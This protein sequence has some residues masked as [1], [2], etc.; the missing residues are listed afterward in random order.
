MASFPGFWFCTEMLSLNSSKDTLYILASW[1]TTSLTCVLFHVPRCT[2]MWTLQMGKVFQT[3]WLCPIQQSHMHTCPDRRPL[4]WQDLQD[5]IRSAV[6]ITLT[7]RLMCAHTHPWS[8]HFS[9]HP[10]MQRSQA[11]NTSQHCSKCPWKSDFLPK[12]WLNIRLMW[13]TQ[14]HIDPYPS[15]LGLN[16]CQDYCVHCNHRRNLTTFP[17]PHHGEAGPW[18]DETLGLVVSNSSQLIDPDWDDGIVPVPVMIIWL[19]CHICIIKNIIYLKLWINDSFIPSL[20]LIFLNQSN[21]NVLDFTEMGVWMKG[22]APQRRPF[23]VQVVSR[24]VHEKHHYV[25]HRN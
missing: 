25:N 7:V 5:V 18:A 14:T 13:L 10:R 23:T 19:K 20:N 24:I 16:H 4:Q 6:Q 8:L 1:Q 12:L 3:H 17:V 21:H 2:Q 11:C 15:G 22:T 9:V